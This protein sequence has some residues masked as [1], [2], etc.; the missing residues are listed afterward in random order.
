MSTRR[1]PT[2]HRIACSLL[3]AGLVWVSLPQR[4]PAVESPRAESGKHFLWQVDSPT[5]RAYLLGSIHLLRQDVY[6][7]APVIEEAFAA[8]DVLVLEADVFGKSP[9]V[10][11][12]SSLDNAMYAPG[13]TLQSELDPS[14]Y[15]EL[16]GLLSQVGIPTQTVQQYRPWFLSLMVEQV[17]WAR[18]GLQPEYGIDAY[19]HRKAEGQ[20]PIE[21]LESVEA[22]LAM[23]STLSDEE[24]VLLLSWTMNDL[25]QTA[26]AFEQLLQLWQRGDAKAM[27][28][29]LRK[30]IEEEPRFEPIWKRLV[31]DRNLDMAERIG[32]FLASHRRY[33]VVVGAAHLIGARGLISLLR[34]RGYAVQ[35]L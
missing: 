18:L 7:L 22:Q 34:Q 20:K 27:E 8:S 23:L 16:R 11:L 35:Q 31:D 4:S 33:F 9:E 10:L 6:P 15:V 13:R 30:D 25:D 1:A 14:D 21:E 26:Q 12:Q 5:A 3:A 28:Q 2:I 29:Q 19:F 17:L 24:Q 32:A